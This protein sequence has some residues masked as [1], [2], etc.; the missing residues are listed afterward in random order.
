MNIGD[1]GYISREKSLRSPSK[2]KASRRADEPLSPLPLA[3]I[4]HDHFS[5]E[6][7]GSSDSPKSLEARYIQFPATPKR[8][9]HI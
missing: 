7:R 4:P 2:L 6:V 9:S 8:D 5:G 1:C 3:V